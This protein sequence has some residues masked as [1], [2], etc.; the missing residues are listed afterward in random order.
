M[1]LATS[2]E[3]TVHSNNIQDN[4]NIYPVRLMFNNIAMRHPLATA[5]ADIEK[6]RKK[7]KPL[8]RIHLHSIA[9]K[10][11]YDANNT[12]HNID[13]LESIEE[14]DKLIDDAMQAHVQ[15]L[16]KMRVQIL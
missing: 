12:K 11:N 6:L 8:T 5:P 2:F 10:Y 1:S 14:I 9:S 15:K 7:N 4:S 13:V 3:I 16:Q